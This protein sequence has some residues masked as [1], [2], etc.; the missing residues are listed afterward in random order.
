MATKPRS[1]DMAKDMV[2][3]SRV[4]PQATTSSNNMANNMAAA[5]M[6]LT[7]MAISNTINSSVLQPMVDSSTARLAVLNMV[8]LPHHSNKHSQ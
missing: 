8:D 7:N 3:T 5:S 4:L 1:K 6:P 2:A